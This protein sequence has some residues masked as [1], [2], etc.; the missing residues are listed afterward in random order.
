M[1][2]HG[3]AL[4]RRV[5]VEAPASHTIVVLGIKCASD[6]LANVTKQPI[7]TVAQRQDSDA[8]Y[9]EMKK[10]I[11]HSSLR[12]TFRGIACMSMPLAR[13]TR[14]F[15]MQMLTTAFVTE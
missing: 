4:Y 3:G 5:A 8:R 9:M 2:W 12:L 1:N 6:F 7:L 11:R 13:P 10:G 14:L 15:P